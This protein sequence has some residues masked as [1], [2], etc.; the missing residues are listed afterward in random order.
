MIAWFS[1]MVLLLL[2]VLRIADGL[3]CRPAFLSSPAIA[4]TGQVFYATAR[5]PL[6]LLTKTEEVLGRLVE[7][8]LVCGE[9]PS[10][11]TMKSAM[12]RSHSFAVANF[13]GD[14]KRLASSSGGNRNPKSAQLSYVTR[15]GAQEDHARGSSESWARRAAR[16][17]YGGEQSA[18]FFAADDFCN[19]L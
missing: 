12:P 2:G 5:E 1:M 3:R 16:M 15:S 7:S 10:L 18:G 8:P 9:L 17:D 11:S 4:S 19:R 14:D 13:A 6:G